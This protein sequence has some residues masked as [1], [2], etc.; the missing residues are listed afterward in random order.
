MFNL[1]LEISQI[2]SQKLLDSDSPWLNPF[3]VEVFFWIAMVP[4]FLWF[5]KR[6][7]VWVSELES[8]FTRL[9]RRRTM[10]VVMF[11]L[12]ALGL[13]L[14]VLPIKPVPTPAVHDEFSYIMQAQ[15]FNAGR[16]T[17][18]VH[19]LWVHFET[20]HVNMR[21]TYQSMYPPG[22]AAFL[23]V[24]LRLFGDPWFGVLLG[25]CLMCA[26][27]S[28]ML[29]GW[30][31]PQW[32]LLGGLF[33]VLRFAVFGKWIDSYYGGATAAFAGALLL[34]AIPRIRG[35]KHA[36]AGAFIFAF[37]LA[38]LANTRQYE[39][40]VLSLIPLGWLAW[41]AVREW[42]KERTLVLKVVAC[43]LLVMVPVGAFMLY[44]NWRS[45]GNALTMPYMINQKTYHI[46]KPFFGQ[47]AYP[48]PEYNHFDMRKFYIF[49]EL[50]D[51]MRSREWWGIKQIIGKKTLAYYALF[52]WPL[53]I[54]A[55]PAAWIGFKSRRLRLLLAT[56]ALLAVGL[57]VIIWQ[58][59][60]QYPSPGIAVLIALL[61][62]IVRLTRTIRFRR[63]GIGLA[64]SRTIVAA[65]ALMLTASI[66]K[67]LWNPD[68]LTHFTYL[69]PAP[70]ERVRIV[71]E[72]SKAPGKH[73][74]IV[75]THYFSWPGFEWVY[76]EHD[77]DGSKIVW[78][79]DMGADRNQRLTDYFADRQ[80][81]LVDTDDRRLVA[82]KSSLPD[83]PEMAQLLSRKMKQGSASP[84]LANK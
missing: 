81:W 11:G 70:V 35:K 33:C 38:L 15:T 48:V 13:R 51:Y 79:R 45:T 66:G 32:A 71:S 83:I 80:I 28:W 75:R 40:F 76:N 47:K 1:V 74:V 34:G 65:I 53:L 9:S 14:A 61:L 82:Y 3:I 62:L 84:K 17:N 27:I 49:H 63:L 57:L 42:R 50:P 54:A 2:F 5:W 73:L 21:P 68:N 7:P 77:I 64:M 37:G 44:Y 31:P 20:F 36:I 30:M 23:T 26:A 12:M 41:W 6:P 52:L 19:P 39:G 60:E 16:L 46:T 69:I 22:Q 43:G 67:S 59:E 8:F 56:G 25:M 29:Q 18:P 58:P 4:V 55:V 10:C 24:G 72:L 78:A